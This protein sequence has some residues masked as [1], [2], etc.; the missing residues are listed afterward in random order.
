MFKKSVFVIFCFLLSTV[1][2]QKNKIILEGIV[3]D[4]ESITIPYAAI[5][6]ASKNI[7]TSTTEEGKFYLSLSMS[8]LSDT[9]LISSM[10]FE[11]KRIQIQNFITNKQKIIVLKENITSLT[12]VE[13]L[14]PE[15]FIKKARKQSKENFVSDNHRLN[16]LYRRSSV[17]QNVSKFFVEQY[18]A[19]RY[20]GPTSYLS[21]IQVLESRKS[22]DYRIANLKQ[23]MHSVNFMA[24]NN[25]LN[26][27]QLLK[28]MMWKKI[29]DT[30]YDGEGVV[31]IE[32]KAKHSR[33]KFYIGVEDYSIYKTESS[34]LDAV[35]I[36]KKNKEGKLYLSYHNRT[37]KTKKEISSNH[38][39]LMK[40][41]Q[42]QMNVSYRHEL[43][44]L[45]IET[46]KKNM[47]MKS[48]GGYDSDMGDIEIPY[49]QTFWRN[50]SLPP[51]TEFYKK[52]KKELESN[53]GVPLEQQYLYSNKN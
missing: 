15:D 38:Q 22:A 8:N 2:A 3:I 5:T 12:T 21:K 47:K 29:G 30:N 40:L 6:I 23:N 34:A 35:Y 11:T 31:I 17:E 36:Y 50:F 4:K 52:I 51:E 13:I 48:F 44:V 28:K 10:G 42:P 45:G 39:K 19:F 27:P 25:P 18:L 32:G 9:L 43:F 33:A 49:N 7:G 16:V 20:K 1:S 46:D 41:K 14:K 26:N 53:Y 24:D 37:W